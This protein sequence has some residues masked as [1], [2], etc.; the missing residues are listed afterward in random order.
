MGLGYAGVAITLDLFYTPLGPYITLL[1]P[2]LVR[3]LLRFYRLADF[4]EPS[5]PRCRGYTRLVC[6]VSG[7]LLLRIKAEMKSRRL[8]GLISGPFPYPIS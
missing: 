7:I 5:Y 4:E 8:R 2:L 1:S 3:A 6:Q